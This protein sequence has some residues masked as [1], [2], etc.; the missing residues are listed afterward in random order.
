MEEVPSTWMSDK[1][2]NFGG[3]IGLR[4]SLFNMLSIYIVFSFQVCNR[5]GKVSMLL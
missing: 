2:C 5:D 1:L 4:F 3:I